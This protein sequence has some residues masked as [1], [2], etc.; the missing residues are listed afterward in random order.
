ME[1][2]NE[3]LVMEI[4]Y[5]L[6]VDSILQCIQSFQDVPFSLL[7]YPMFVCNPIT[8]EY[9]N[10]PRCGVKEKDFPIGIRCGIGYD[11]SNNVYKVVVAS[12]NMH[13]LGSQPNRLQVYTLGDVNGWR[14]IKIPYDLSGRCIHVDGT[15]FWLDDERC[16]IIAFDLT[17]EVFELLPKPPFCTPNNTYYSKLHILRKGL[18][19][20]LE[21]NSNLEIWLVKK[22]KNLQMHNSGTGESTDCWSWMKELSMSWEGLGLFSMTLDLLP[23]TVSKNGQVLIWDYK[24]KALF[25][26]DKRTSTAKE[27]IDDDV[28]KVEYFRSLPHIN[29]FVSLKS[30]GMK[31]EWI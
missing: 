3:E 25:L 7:T 5:R 1:N 4:L 18:C 24:K 12:H 22:K 19:I 6:P 21:H 8:G 14:N 11:Y 15:F 10:L 9:V 30:L 29:S 26:Y 2:L 23:V 20:V 17:D 31:S 13:E 16:N 27:I 28:R